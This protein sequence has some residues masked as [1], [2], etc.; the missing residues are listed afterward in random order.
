MKVDFKSLILTTVVNLYPNKE[1][2]TYKLK[3]LVE[4]KIKDHEVEIRQHSS[5]YKQLI[6]Y[7]YVFIEKFIKPIVD[8][9]KYMRDINI[10]KRKWLTDKV[11]K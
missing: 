11:W 2:S 6:D 9:K 4:E 8:D 1:I 7:A 10:S 3:W 5:N